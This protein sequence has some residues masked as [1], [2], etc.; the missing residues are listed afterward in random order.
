MWS[1]QSFISSP[2][3]ATSTTF[4]TSCSRELFSFSGIIDT[5]NMVLRHCDLRSFDALP[6]PAIAPHSLK[7]T[8]E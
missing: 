5:Y 8:M 1:L 2:S 7:A 3:L 4:V 6:R